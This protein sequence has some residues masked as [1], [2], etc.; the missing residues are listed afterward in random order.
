[1]DFMEDKLLWHYRT[2]NVEQV[3]QALEQLDGTP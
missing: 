1:V 3:K 2:P